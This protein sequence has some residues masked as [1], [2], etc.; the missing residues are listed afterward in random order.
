MK[1]ALPLFFA[2]LCPLLAEPPKRG[3]T[4]D[5]PITEFKLTV[6]SDEGFRSSLLRGSEAHYINDNQIDLVGM[7]YSTFLENEAGDLDATLLAPTA[8]VFINNKK[9]KVQG[10]GA[11]RLLRKDLDVTGEKWTYEH[12]GKHDSTPKKLVIERN[13]H[14]IFR[15]EMKDMLK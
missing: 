10:D 5:A 13:V 11:M 14:V 6:F 3:V 2:L 15:I 9:V 12:A 4:S 8:T 1:R 7:Q